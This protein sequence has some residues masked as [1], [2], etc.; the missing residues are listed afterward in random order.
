M[1]PLGTWFVMIPPEYAG[2]PPA[3]KELV[4]LVIQYQAGSQAW[5]DANA[6]RIVQGA[7][8]NTGNPQVSEQLVRWKGPYATQDQAKKAQ[9]A[10]QQSP[11][12]FNDLANAAENSSALGAIGQLGN[13]FSDLTQ[14]NTWLRIFKILAG[15]GLVLI[16]I[17]HLSAKT[18]SGTAVGAAK[19]AVLA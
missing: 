9:N 10:K 7:E 3:E 18:V 16:G 2:K 6:G 11:N 14:R 13:F 12:P 5:K 1:T 4:D 19:A 15:F 8:G 17:V